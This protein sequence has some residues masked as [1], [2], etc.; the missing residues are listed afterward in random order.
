[1]DENKIVELATDRP[2]ALD[3]GKN[4]V[5]IKTAYTTYGELNDEKSNAVLSCS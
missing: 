1:M 4:L 5:P 3:C 2:L